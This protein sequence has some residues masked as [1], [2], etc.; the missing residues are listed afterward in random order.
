MSTF[1]LAHTTR[2]GRHV[3]VSGCGRV[4][5]VGVFDLSNDFNEG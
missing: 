5:S 4:I 3:G 1:M 2:V